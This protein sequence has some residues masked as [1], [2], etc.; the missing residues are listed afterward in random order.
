M[1]KTLIRLI[2]LVLAI[3]MVASLA[4]GCGGNEEATASN[5]KVDTSSQDSVTDEVEEEDEDE[6]TEDESS[7]E[8]DDDDDDK[9]SS[10][11]SSS[12]KSSSKKSSSKKSSSK[13]SSS[14]KSSSKKSSSN[15]TSSNKKPSAPG[16]D[17]ID[18]SVNP[19]DYKG[20][21]VT[22]VTWKDPKL[23]EDGV[24][25]DKFE[26]DFGMK[27]AVQLIGQG[28]YVKT[29]Q[30]SI[31]SGT[32]G[33]IFF[34]NGDFP[35]SLTV[36]QPLDAAMLDLSAPIWNQ[37]LIKAS[38]LDGHPYLVDCISN[39]WTEVDICVY[40]KNL[41][42][43]GGLNTPSDYYAAGK[44]SFDNFEYA[45][46]Q[47][48]ALGKDYI[49]AGV[50]GEA[51]LGAA[52]SSFF[53]YKDNKMVVTA[54]KHLY[55]VMNRLCKMK[56]DGYIKL[57]RGG[58][59]EGK[60]GMALTNCF[61]LKRTGYFTQINPDHLGA[62]YLPVWKEGDKQCVTGIYRGW[63]LID[64]AKNPVGAGLFL[65]Q[66]LDVNNYDLDATFH[67]QEVAN[68]F[69]QVTGTY[70]DNM[71]YYHGPDMVKS[72]GQGSNFHESW[73]S[74]TPANMTGYL[75]SQKPVMEQMCKKANE[76]IESHRKKLAKG[77]FN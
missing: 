17:G 15:K 42:E 20:T 57:D 77:D 44:W 28:D 5:S 2:T 37:A 34:E 31:A 4:V 68:F 75:D 72:T 74:Q 49:G 36:M 13:K 48:S 71:I 32:Q 33:D 7:E 41:F 23:N 26:K 39:V 64:G 67:N 24:A 8:E 69:F 62:T 18:S 1:S 55:E 43:K 51:A 73:H 76:I 47:I 45:A 54:D 9:S 12:K 53:T 50:L 65:R 66:Y 6:A 35:G 46:K 38:T 11:K 19:D 21:T 52:G 22:Y 25:V 59:G 27:V 58:F 61:G 56:A 10:K 60:Q 29:I 63:G 16:L 70:S 14:K 40:N 30:A 3:C